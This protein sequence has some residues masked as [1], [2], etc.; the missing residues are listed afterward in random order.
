MTAADRFDRHF[1][2]MLADV[3]QPAYPDYIDDVLERATR[4]SQ[5]PA[6]TFPER[7]LPMRTLTRSVPFAPG[8]PWRN[9]GMLALLAILAAALL[10]IAIGTQQ[11][12]AP[13]YGL[14]ANGAIVYQVDGDIFTRTLPDG[15]P[16]LIGGGLD[17][18]VTPLFSL[19]GTKMAF[20][21]IDPDQEAF[22]T[23]SEQ[24]S[25][26]VANADGSGLRTVFGPTI[27]SDWTWS[28]DGRSLAV[29]GPATRGKQ[30][31]I[32][33]IDGGEPRVLTD[34]HGLVSG[35]QWRPPDGRE[36]IVGLASGGRARFFAVPAEGGEPRQIT[37]DDV[38]VPR[39]GLF[40]VTPDGRQVVYEHA[41]DPA[42]T[43]RILDI[44]TG[45][46]RVFGENLPRPDGAGIVHAGAPQVSADGKQ[47]V[48]GRWW[49]A[50]STTIIHQI[51]TAS[52]DGDGSDAAPVGQPFRTPQGVLPFVYTSSP[53][54]T[55]IVVHRTG[56]SET[57]ST[58]LEGAN[59]QALDIGDFEWIDWQ[60]LAP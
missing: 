32:V 18:D 56:T 20:V 46:E 59:R 5:R 9:L 25:L 53:D 29:V 45:E 17:V 21:R 33:P 16:R 36:L 50:D 14:A 49:G 19:D 2:D 13:P 12:P 58:N 22:G 38:L 54:G 51:W 28:P 31:S 34:V 1:A 44:D 11:R 48:F 41:E 35:S 27:F 4:G 26:V 47:L 7:W 15:E 10:A 40:V 23:M 30:L 55:Q 37:P 8:V 39:V 6:W 3:A 57:W 24:A 42:M 52:L 43:L 60:R